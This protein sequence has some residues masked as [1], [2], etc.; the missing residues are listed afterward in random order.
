MLVLNIPPV[1]E[2]DLV[3]YLL[4]QPAVNGFTSY[5]ARGHGNDLIMNVAE[6]VT[7]RCKRVQVEILIDE[8]AVAKLLGGLRASVGTDITY[9]E[10]QVK[11]IGEIE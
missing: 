5:E 11:N 1:L 7:G 2:D 6:Q 8:K 10:H 4:L 3:D 9:W